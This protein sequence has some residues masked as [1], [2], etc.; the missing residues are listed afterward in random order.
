[1]LYF[2]NSKQVS[3]FPALDLQQL[4]NITLSANLLRRNPAL[5]LKYILQ[6]LLD[7]L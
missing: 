7:P 2:K 6:L 4:Y 3:Y 1:M 5:L